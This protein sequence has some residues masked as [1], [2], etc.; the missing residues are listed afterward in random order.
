MWRT[1]ENMIL[2]AIKHNVGKG[3]H[4]KEQTEWLIDQF[5][6]LQDQ[7]DRQQHHEDFLLSELKKLG[8]F[9]NLF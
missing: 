3:Y 4:S 7:L 8:W 9:D 1:K 6:K 2:A 5:E